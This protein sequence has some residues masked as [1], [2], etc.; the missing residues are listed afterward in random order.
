MRM[1]Q[2][3][4]RK[5]GKPGTDWRKPVKVVTV[6]LVHEIYAEAGDGGSG[7]G[8]NV[9]ETVRKSTHDKGRIR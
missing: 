7:G 1:A 3:A 2:I 6:A 8:L 5:R 9:A 4:A